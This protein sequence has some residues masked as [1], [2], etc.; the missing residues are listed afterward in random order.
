MRR[1]IPISL[2]A[3]TALIPVKAASQNVRNTKLTVEQETFVNLGEVVVLQIPS[4]RQYSIITAG[5]ALVPVRRSKNQLSY[6]AVRTGLQ[7]IVLRPEVPNGECVSCSSLHYFVLV[8][9]R[10]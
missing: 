9:S 10:N 8:V 1:L 5:N 3:L 2:L 6:R 4:D 7:T